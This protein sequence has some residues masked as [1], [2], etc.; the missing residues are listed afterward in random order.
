MI[1]RIA[2]ITILVLYNASA[3]ASQSE[4]SDLEC[5]AEAVYYEARSEPVIGMLAVTTVIITRLKSG[6]YGDTICNVVHYKCHFSY[7]CDGKPERLS[8]KKYRKIAFSI[9]RMALEGAVVLDIRNADHY[10][11]V[12]VKPEW[13]SKMK[14]LGRIGTH[15]FY[16]DIK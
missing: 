11:A 12:Y 9:A 2:L 1:I 10:H 16:E 5:L 4:Q 3:G 15:L 6:K 14:F 7:W 13:A 8:N